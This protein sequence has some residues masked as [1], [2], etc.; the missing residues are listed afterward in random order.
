MSLKSLFRS[1]TSDPVDSKGWEV[2]L[3]YPTNSCMMEDYDY[4]MGLL[5]IATILKLDGFRMKCITSKQLL[6]QPFTKKRFFYIASPKIVGITVDSDNYSNAI[7][8][9]RNVRKWLPRTKIFAGG[10]LI[11]IIKEKIMEEPSFD[12]ATVGEGEYSVRD[13]CRLV[14]R[15]EGSLEEIPGLIYR[16]EDGLGI[17]A[18]NPPIKDLDELPPVDYSIIGTGNVVNYISGRGCPFSCNFCCRTMPSGYRFFSPDRVVSDLIRIGERGCNFIVIVDD[19]FI[20]NA[21]RVK[22]I[23]VKLEEAKRRRLLKFKLF[24]EARVDMICRHPELVGYLKRA[25]FVKIQL[26][27]ESGVQRTLD[28]YNKRVTLE[29]IEK[30]VEIIYEN[31]PLLMTG[32]IIMAA[33]FETEET[34][35]QSLDFA[36][37]LM[38]KAP[39]YLEMNYPILCPYPSTKIGDHPEEYGLK[40]VDR[41]WYEGMT[42]HVAA[43]VPEGL[44]RERVIGMRAQAYAETEQEYAKIA[45][46]LPYKDILFH[47][48][49]KN[50]GGNGAYFRALVSERP[51]VDAYFFYMNKPGFFRMKDIREEDLLDIYPI[52]VYIYPLRTPDFKHFRLSGNGK[53]DYVMTDPAEEE[54]YALSYGKLCVGSIAERLRKHFPGKSAMDVV[55]DFMLP[56]FKRWEDDY[57]VVFNL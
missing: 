40:V 55:R 45:R 14:V 56:V 16:T 35:R 36:K 17:N 57:Q 6:N 43:C 24:C 11:N 18:P 49:I 37:R 39:G 23:C 51:T 4:P 52:R 1:L 12:F 44:T 3:M 46:S 50:M 47:V 54:L 25:G 29:Q 32:N 41:E 27:I 15:G 10:P 53:E 9:A 7:D 2:V 28:L 34:F 13:L 19:T 8:L 5:S 48:D 26:G 42:T 33:P 21:D 20:A 31:G 22:E 30:A 38:N